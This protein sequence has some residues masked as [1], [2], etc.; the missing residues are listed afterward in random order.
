MAEKRGSGYIFGILSIVFAFFVPLAGIILGIIGL[1]LNKKEKSKKA[2]RLN[3]IGI[4][5]GAI[6]FL[7]SLAVTYLSIQN[8]PT[9]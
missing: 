1:V 2:R 3:I 6:L 8:F 4:I 7:A 9:Y 5:I